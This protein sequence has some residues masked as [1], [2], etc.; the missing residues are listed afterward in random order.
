MLHFAAESHVYRSIHG[1]EDFI[2]TNIIGTA[3]STSH[4]RG[5]RHP[6]H[7]RSRFAE[8]NAYKPNIPYSASKAA[9]DHTPLGR[10]WHHAYGLH[11]LSP[12]AAITKGPNFPEKL[13]DPTFVQ[14][15]AGHLFQYGRQV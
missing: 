14:R 12:T 11:C 9:S 8:T 3:F 1:H 2:Q 7:Q 10:A 4:R 15:Q 5:L 13:I 6:E